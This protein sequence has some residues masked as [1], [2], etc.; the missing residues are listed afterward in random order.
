[1]RKDYDSLVSS[2]QKNTYELRNVN[3][4]L[5]EINKKIQRTDEHLDSEIN[6]IITKFG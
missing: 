4:E 1:M 3:S 6:K 5:R 2:T